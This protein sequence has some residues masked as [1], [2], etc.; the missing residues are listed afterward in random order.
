MMMIK[1]LATG[2]GSLP[3]KDY[4]EA[5][6]LVFQY[7]PEIPFWPQLPKKDVREGM[8]AQ[9]S[10]NLP[11]LKVSADG[12]YF[13]CRARD[14]ELETFYEQIRD[15]QPAYFFKN[16]TSYVGLKVSQKSENFVIISS[17]V[18]LYGLE[19]MANLKSLLFIG[20]LIAMI[21]IQA[22]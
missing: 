17:A 15:N 18:D 19:E 14:E 7:C 12:V 4:S 21:F 11:C 5:L 3:Y 22:L 20:F 16:N 1:G 8:M 6:D 13:D 10:Q 2:I 9:F